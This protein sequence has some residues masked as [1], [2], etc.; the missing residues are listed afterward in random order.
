MIFKDVS[1]EHPFAEHIKWLKDNNI[2]KGYSDGTYKPE[3]TI[4]R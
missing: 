1:E 4:T 2:T 3:Q